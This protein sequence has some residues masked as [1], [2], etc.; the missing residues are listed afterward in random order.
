MNHSW[1]DG[2]RS[3]A[4]LARQPGSFLTREL[5]HVSNEGGSHFGP[6]QELASVTPQLSG[7]IAWIFRKLW[8]KSATKLTK[9]VASNPGMH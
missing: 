9:D 2:D 7:C 4:V 6:Q 5:D 3:D 1:L 8:A